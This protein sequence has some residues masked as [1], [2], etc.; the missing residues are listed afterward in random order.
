MTLQG[1]EITEVPR[2]YIDET[3]S[4]G[5]ATI[6]AEVITH[7]YN[8]LR[9]F[10]SAL[11]HNHV[12]IAFRLQTLDE[13]SHIFYVS[14]TRYHSTSAISAPFIAQFPNFSIRPTQ[15]TTTMPTGP[16]LCVGMIRG[17][18]HLTKA[19]LNALARFLSGFHC[20][21][22]YQAWAHPKRPGRIRRYLTQLR[23]QSAVKQSQKQDTS[24]S[25]LYGTTT[26]THLDAESQRRAKRF[27]LEFERFSSKL[28]LDCR[29]MLAFWGS[30]ES[31][32]QLKTALA[33]L[34]GCISHDDK[35]LRLKTK[36]YDRRKAR[37][38]FLEAL[39]LGAKTPGT[40]LLPSE[41][42]PYFALPSIDL[43]I[44][45]T[46]SA[47]FTTYTSASP[48]KEDNS[49]NR[50]FRR[51]HIA[52]GLLYRHGQLESSLVSHMRTE[53]LR[54]H[55]AILGM[56]G[57]GKSTTKNRIVIDA[58]RNEIP[59]LL[60]EPVK[61]DARDLMGAI[62]DLRVFTLGNEQVAPFRLNPFYVEDGVHIHSH[63]NLLVSCFMAAW[64]V[65]GILA[66]Y[67][68][69]VIVQ[70]Y[71][72]HGWDLVNNRR[73]TPIALEDFRLEGEKFSQNLGYGTELKQDF[74]G[75]IL[76]RA[77][78]LCDPARAVIFNTTS[79]LSM[80]ELLSKPT[81][82]E[83]RHIAD[84]E[85][86]AFILSLLLIRVYEHFDRLGPAK[87]IRG[88]LVIDEAH[89]VLEE[90]PRA[91]D[92]NDAASSQRRAVDQL[93]DLIAEARSLGLG[94]IL[95]DQNPTR[96]ARDALK[97]C[98][99]KIVH[100]LTSPEDRNLLALET[101]CSKEQA[102]QIDVLRVGEVVFRGPEDAVPSNVQ[103]IHDAESNPEMKRIWT[104]EDVHQRMLQFYAK[105]PEFAK[106]PPIPSLEPFDLIEDRESVTLRVQLEDIVRSSAYA[107]NYKDAVD[108]P[109][110]DVLN[111]IEE[112]LVF[113]ASNLVQSSTP[114]MDILRI[115]LEITEE[116]YGTPPYQLDWSVIEDLAVRSQHR[117]QSDAEG[118]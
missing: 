20:N 1:I 57:F 67:L 87:H 9:Q 59:S 79:D 52:L 109:D 10:L 39:K 82:I 56:T 99:T 12:P 75:A 89:T 40:P 33:I 66:N 62:P 50:V 100:R 28:F 32:T 38:V 53:D 101:G 106:T 93:V 65:Y 112:Q 61:T 78:D 94:T 108:D 22:M 88:L 116:V 31:M 105:H 58:W 18:P 107:E 27:A 4:S 64:P 43:G 46:H 30:Q 103:V 5:H 34:L 24:T 13:D 6:S 14:R 84:P 68:R 51:G 118:L 63:V 17:L 45:Q 48:N 29:V 36:I 91:A 54:K 60:I 104:D 15:L 69:R 37:R 97:T 16:D 77:E 85:L 74:R 114:L 35:D 102:Q 26:R 23:Y 76:G 3:S 70:T 19:P 111:A 117:T 72:N 80:N 2:S 98:S 42:V 86:R 25:F 96:L 113:Y 92:M 95:C 49:S 73:G 115:M 21:S 7:R 47:S 110:S 90:I 11:M 71:V 83:L 81:V 8:P 41:A 44:K 55:V